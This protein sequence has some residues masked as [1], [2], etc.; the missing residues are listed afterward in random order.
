MNPPARNL[1]SLLRVS[2]LPRPLPSPTARQVPSFARTFASTRQP[3]TRSNFSPRSFQ[4]NALLRLPRR[5]LR[6]KSDKK[7]SQK[8][9]PT[10]HLGSPE[11]ALSLS[12]RLK[13][14]GREYGWLALG[15]YMGLSL[16]DFPLCFLTVR[17][18]G[19]DRIG[20]YEHVIVE[21]FKNIIRIPFPSLWEDSEPNITDE[22][23]E[24]TEREGA[25]GTVAAKG[26]KAEAC[27]ISDIY[28][29]HDYN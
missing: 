3:V 25:V 23:V 11:P 21:G 5:S 20:H 16:L 4:Q 12:Q 1:A 13:K 7:P 28:S 24:A 27:M 8:P 19:T 26:T 9:D 17:M 18:L 6:F 15:V 10:P 2:L 14:L 29:P 22:V